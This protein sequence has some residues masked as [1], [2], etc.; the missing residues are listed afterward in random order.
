MLSSGLHASC[1]FAK[2]DLFSKKSENCRICSVGDG[3]AIS[4]VVV[5]MSLR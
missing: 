4:A 1:C 5:Q 2:F 3:L